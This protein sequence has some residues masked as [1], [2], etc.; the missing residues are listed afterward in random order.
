[1][2][3]Y[4]IHKLQTWHVDIFFIFHDKDILVNNKLFLIYNN[5]QTH[6]Q[7]EVWL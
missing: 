1:M 4:T 5:K 7:W 3:T 2:Q 6:E